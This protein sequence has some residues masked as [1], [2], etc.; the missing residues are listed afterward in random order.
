MYLFELNLLPCDGTVNCYDSVFDPS[1]ADCLYHALFEKIDW[2]HD[3]VKIMGKE[4]ITKRK[5]AWH[6]S[7]PYEYRYSGV[8]KNALPWNET[9]L[10][11]KQKIEKQTG[12]QFNS[13]LLNLYH[14]GKEGMA[15]HCDNEKMLKKNAAIASVSF[16]AS[17]TFSFKHKLS[18][19]KVNVSLHHGTLLMMKEETQQ[20]WL[21]CLPPTTKVVSPRINL[22]FR[23]IES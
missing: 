16:G 14:S 5:V 2:E 10:A 4:I 9:L 12:E 21:H 13:C 6:G 22:T 18:G 1:E 3:K 15:W 19:V 7:E 11:I 23:T 17:R 8:S 20:H